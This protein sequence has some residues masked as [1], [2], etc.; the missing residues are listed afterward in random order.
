MKLRWVLLAVLMFT[1][2]LTGSVY[3]ENGSSYELEPFATRYAAGQSYL[4]TEA[5]ISAYTQVQ[6]VD[7]AKAA[8]AMKTVEIQTSEYVIGTVGIEG[9]DNSHDVHVYV[10]NSNWVIAYYLADEKAAKIIDWIAYAGANNQITRNKLEVALDDVCNAM[11][12][13]VSGVSYYDFRFPEATNIIIITDE[14]LSSNTTETFDIMIPSSIVV[15]NRVWSYAK[16]DGGYC[17][18]KIDE[19]IL[20][21]VDPGNGWYSWN[22]DIAISL[23]S[24]DVYH[25]ISI[26]NGSYSINSYVGIVL[27]YKQ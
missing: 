19:T 6:M 25:T 17:D 26:N 5:G 20:N 27:I 14:E 22:G 10:D 9:Y 7:L 15:Y 12:T 16:N 13:Y 23:L 3:A 18:I 1:L 11:Q 4:E 8:G 21:K 24:P 2:C